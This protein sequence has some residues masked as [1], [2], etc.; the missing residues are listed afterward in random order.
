M[1]T[2]APGTY[3]PEHAVNAGDATASLPGVTPFMEKAV[4][5]YILNQ[6]NGWHAIDDVPRQ[7]MMVILYFTDRA[8]LCGDACRNLKFDLAF[9]DGD[10]FRDLWTG[11]RFGEFD[12][13]DLPT[14]WR[15]MPA[16]PVAS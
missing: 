8:L 13:K 4:R 3:G 10:H 14:Y 2:Q 15:N 12:G 1:S 16:A 5:L 6:N 11:H 9:Y 7:P